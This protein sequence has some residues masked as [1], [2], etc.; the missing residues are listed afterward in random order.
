MTD[1]QAL[2]YEIATLQTLIVVGVLIILGAKKRW[3]FLVDPPESW[4][5]F[6]SQALLKK[7]FGT[8][9]VILLCYIGGAMC[10]GIASIQIAQRLILLGK[11]LGYWQ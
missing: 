11:A 3:G 5:W 4:W 10:V 1:V 2:L 8:K 9:G 7:L 6:Y